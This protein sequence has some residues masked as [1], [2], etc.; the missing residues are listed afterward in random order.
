MLCCHKYPYEYCVFLDSCEQAYFR[1]MIA[2][3]KDV[4]LQAVL[5]SHT[6]LMPETRFC[7]STDLSEVFMKPDAFQSN[8][9]IQ[10]QNTLCICF[11]V[12]TFT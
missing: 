11:I 12:C 8:T 6:F 7:R 5:A 9:T 3:H 10:R 1:R 4:L 2:E